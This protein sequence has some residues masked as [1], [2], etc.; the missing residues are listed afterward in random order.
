MSERNGASGEGLLARLA[1]LADELPQAIAELEARRDEIDADLKRLR[2]L[3]RTL[4]PDRPTQVAPKKPQAP[5]AQRIS[6]EKV[7]QVAAAILTL[8]ETWGVSDLFEFK[9]GSSPTIYTTIKLLRERELI[10]RAGKARGGGG[11]TIQVYRV[12]DRDGLETVARAA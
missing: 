2:G 1:V 6:P 9:I 3:Q 11:Q 12:L 8:P 5:R 7:K 4:G 10:G